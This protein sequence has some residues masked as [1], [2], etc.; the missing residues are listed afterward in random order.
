MD[1]PLKKKQFMHFASD[2]ITKEHDY[3]DIEYMIQKLLETSGI[4]T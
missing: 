3:D 4:V 1:I 2:H